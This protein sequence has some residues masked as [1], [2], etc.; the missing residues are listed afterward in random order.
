MAVDF[1]RRHAYILEGDEINWILNKKILI[2]KKNSKNSFLKIQKNLNYSNKKKSENIEKCKI[3]EKFKIP[4][5][6]SLKS[7]QNLECF[8]NVSS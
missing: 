4:E 2:T 3:F 8:L 5:S 7:F 6:E 1:H